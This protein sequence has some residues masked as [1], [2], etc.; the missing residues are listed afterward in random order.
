M[1]R[2]IQGTIVALLGAFLG[3]MVSPGPPPPS[4]P[5]SYAPPPPVG[6]EPVGQITC[7]PPHRMRILA[8]DMVPDPAQSGQPI[9]AWRIA[10]QSDWNGECAT[11]FEVRDQD[12]VAGSGFVQAIRPGRS[13][14]M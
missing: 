2:M 14:Y 1:K 8:L 9:E 7:A 11:Q 10:I 3:C 6:R 13:V 4:A 5:P 12:E